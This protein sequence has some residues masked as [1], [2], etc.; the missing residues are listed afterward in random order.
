MCFSATASFLASGLLTMAGVATYSQVIDR[1]QMMLA[2]IPLLFA[3]QQAAE[4]IVWLSFGYD[5]FAWLR[6]IAAYFFL[7]F[8][9]II[10]PTWVPLSIYCLESMMEFKDNSHDYIRKRLLLYKIMIIIGFLVSCYFIVNLF[11]YNLVVQVFDCHILYKLPSKLTLLKLP[12]IL[13][14]LLT[15]VPLLLSRESM[16]RFIGVLFSFAFLVTYCFYYYLLISVWCFFAALLSILTF[17]VIYKQ[18]NNTYEQP[19]NG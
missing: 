9:F 5:T 12:S 8:A 19:N 3:V 10:W 6:I 17:V 1:R 18:R 2:S 16:I 15:I 14:F 4:G 11:R 13:Y 7:F